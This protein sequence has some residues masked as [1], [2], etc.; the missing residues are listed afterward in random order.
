[1]QQITKIAKKYVYKND[2]LGRF[3]NISLMPNDRPLHDMTV[4]APRM[5]QIKI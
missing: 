2:T 5:E 1:M 3:R 4:N